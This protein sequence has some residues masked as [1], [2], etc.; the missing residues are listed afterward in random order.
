[1]IS[2]PMLLI[3]A[4]ALDNCVSDKAPASVAMIS[5]RPIAQMVRPERKLAQAAG[6]LPVWLCTR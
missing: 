3:H 1:M 4:K 5:V 2:P 6:S